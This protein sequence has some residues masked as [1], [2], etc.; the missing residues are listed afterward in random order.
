MQNPLMKKII[1]LLLAFNTV[2][3]SAQDCTDAYITDLYD[4]VT[5]ETVKFGE[6]I[7]SDGEN[8]ELMMDIYLGDGNVAENRPLIILAFGGAFIAGERTSGDMVYF[9]TEFAKKGYICASIDYRITDAF[10]LLAEENLVKTVVNAVHDGKAAIRYFRKDA[11]TENTYKIDTAAVFIGGTSAGGILAAHLAYLEDYEKL[12]ENWRP[13]VDDLPN[14]LE[15]E[16][17]NPGYC[18]VPNGVF[19]FA[20]AIADTSWFENNDV[21]LYNIHSTHDQTVAYE[22][23]RPLNGLAPITLYGGF[24]MHERMT[25]IGVHSVFD[26][27]IGDEHPP[28]NGTDDTE[29]ARRLEVTEDNLANF[30]NNIIHCNPNNLLA[31]NVQTCANQATSVEETAVNNHLVY[32]NPTKGIFSIKNPEQFSEY[33]VINQL[34]QTILSGYSTSSIDASQLESGIYILKLNGKQSA[35]IRLMIE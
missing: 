28:F 9:A 19:A 11:A 21:P 6:A 32:P 33:S 14:A 29:N 10:S 16:S 24:S 4:N 34:G 22:S 12:P 13:Y 15:G 2:W 26:S 3:L 5:I 17:G 25:N 8:Q 30:L 27:Y 18:S 7:N 1:L 35:T 23:G 31:E 20:G